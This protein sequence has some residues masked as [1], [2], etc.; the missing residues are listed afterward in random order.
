VLGAVLGARA[1]A[2]R[3][4][5]HMIN[6]LYPQ[7]ELAKEIDQFFHAVLPRAQVGNSRQQ[8]CSKFFLHFAK[9]TTNPPLL[10]DSSL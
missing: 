9:E 8:Y 7:S 6:G 2:D 3:L 4:P 5:A 10:Q 1:G